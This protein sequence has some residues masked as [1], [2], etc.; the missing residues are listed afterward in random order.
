MEE[1][2]LDAHGQ[3][4]KDSKKVQSKDDLKWIKMILNM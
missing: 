3:T 2:I 4:K 1:L